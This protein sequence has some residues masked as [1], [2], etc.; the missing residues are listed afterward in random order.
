M[1]PSVPAS[2]GPVSTYFERSDELK[3]SHPFAA[4]HLRLFGVELAMKMKRADAGHFLLAQ[5]DILEAEKK[6]PSCTNPPTVQKAVPTAPPAPPP[7]AEMRSATHCRPRRRAASCQAA[8]CPY[9]LRRPR[10]RRRSR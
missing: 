4:H 9:L 6:Q 7:R 1:A 2:L 3:R 10:R 5:M 8:C